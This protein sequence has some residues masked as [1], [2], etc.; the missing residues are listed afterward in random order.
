M[1]LSDSLNVLFLGSIP[2]AALFHRLWLPHIFL[3]VF[4]SE[5]AYVWYD[6]ASFG[7]IPVLVKRTQLVQANSALEASSNLLMLIGPSLAGILVALLG[8]ALSISVDAGSYVVSACALLLIPRHFQV[9]RDAATLPMQQPTLF[10]DIKEGWHFVWTQPL[11]RTL[12]LLGLGNTFTGGAVQGLVVVYAVQALGLSSTDSR[13]GFLFTVGALGALGA[14]L[15]LPFLVRRVP[16][17]RITLFSLSLTLFPLLGLV[18]AHQLIYGL[19]FYGLWSACSSLTI[20][21]GISLRQQVTPDPLQSRVNTTA[22][23]IQV[24]GTPLGAACGGLLAQMV[25][26]RAAYLFMALGVLVSIVFG[27]CSFLR[28][29]AFPLHDLR[30]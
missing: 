18:W 23:L 6:A 4:L 24:L 1:V 8:A 13:L 10:D 20:I 27:W 19:L 21:N 2:L 5:A 14:S 26:I 29:E 22:R 7:A 25:S 16:V 3:V 28:Q 30:D 9:H 11:V 17:P 12:T 15:W